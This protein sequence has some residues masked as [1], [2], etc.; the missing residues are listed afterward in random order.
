M[1]IR[2]FAYALLGAVV[3]M[4]SLLVASATPASAGCVGFVSGAPA[5]GK[6]R[7]FVERRARLNWT[8]RARARFGREF[9]NWYVAQHRTMNCS[10]VLPSNN[11]SCTAR[12]TACNRPR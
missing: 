5:A 10:K 8:A 11:W 2:K 9:G 12:G 4:G 6:F 1:S 3:F 7:I